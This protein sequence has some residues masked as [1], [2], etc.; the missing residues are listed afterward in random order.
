MGGS[1]GVNLAAAVAPKDSSQLGV[2]IFQ[3]HR[4]LHAI[5]RR[6]SFPGIVQEAIHTREVCGFTDYWS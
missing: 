6:Q 5:M 3:S 4:R 1:A 2:E